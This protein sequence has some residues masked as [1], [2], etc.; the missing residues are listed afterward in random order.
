VTK[1]DHG[2]SAHEDRLIRN[3]WERIERVADRV[4]EMLRE[5]RKNR[6]RHGVYRRRSRCSC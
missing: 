4:L 6:V 5:S 2:Y 3:N 1:H